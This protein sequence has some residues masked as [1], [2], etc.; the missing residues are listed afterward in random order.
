MADHHTRATAACSEDALGQQLRNIGLDQNSIN[1][2]IFSGDELVV[3]LCQN[4][5]LITGTEIQQ[6]DLFSS[7]LL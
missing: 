3:I 5:L 7:F 6:E 2:N 1:N 4:E